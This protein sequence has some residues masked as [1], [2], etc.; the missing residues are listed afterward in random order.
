MSDLRAR[1]AAAPPGTG[2]AARRIV[3]GL[4]ELSPEGR[5][6]L[7]AHLSAN[8]AEYD[9]YHRFER[10]FP[11][12]GPLARHRYP[13][14]LAFLAATERFT[15][16]SLFGGNRVGKTTCAGYAM[17]AFLTGKYKD[18]FPGRR[19]P[20]PVVAWVAGTDTR[21][22]R[23]VIQ[24]L[25]FGAETARGSGLIPADDII[26]TVAKVGT[27]GGIDVAL[28]RHVSGGTSRLLF[29]SYETGAA[30]FAGA[31]A[32][33][34]W[35]DEEP[36]DSVYQEV[37][38]RLT[39]TSPGERSGLLMLSMTPLKGLSEVALKFLPGGRPPETTT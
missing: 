36:P 37:L 23:E 17:T 5:K 4:R 7:L 15:E 18:W 24:P 26:S 2:A 13:R 35:C 38:A 12:N 39:S 20:G 3:D 30:S 28:I 21:V 34:I 1:L 9:R 31:K 8:V 32:D 6:Q 11:D 33:V 14:H 16:V 10:L 29:K 25:L 22:N 19:F 27:P